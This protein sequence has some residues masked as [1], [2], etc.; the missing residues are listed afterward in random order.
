MGVI[1]EDRIG[2][3]GL[4]DG[5]STVMHALIETHIFKAVSIS[6][7]CDDPKIQTNYVGSQFSDFLH[8]VGYP[9]L[10]EGR[11]DFWQPHSLALNAARVS[12]AILIQVSEDEYRSALESFAALRHS[13]RPVEMYVFPDEH[14]IKWQPA[15]RMAVYERNLAWFDFW[16]RSIEDT[17]VERAS[18][19]ARWKAMRDSSASAPARQV[20]TWPTPRRRPGQEGG[21]SPCRSSG[22]IE[23]VGPGRCR[24]R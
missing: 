8:Q 3:T 19:I 24:H 9:S 17:S 5:V 16:L 2:L 11:L 14:H 22:R 4:S 15:H 21:Y 20:A 7:C 6:Q 13:G 1:D 10:D 12:A 23:Q 18:E